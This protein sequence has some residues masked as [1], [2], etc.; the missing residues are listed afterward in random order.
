FCQ[1]QLEHVENEVVPLIIRMLAGIKVVPLGVVDWNLAF[2]RIPV[3]EIVELNRRAVVVRVVDVRVV[4][5]AAPVV[6][7]ADARGLSRA[8]GAGQNRG[9]NRQEQK[10]SQNGSADHVTN[11]P[12]YEPEIGSNAVWRA[13]GVRSPVATV[14]SP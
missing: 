1:R 2:L 4:V 11:P 10:C 12:L 7:L 6:R 13:I 5:E 3:V 8:A 9:Q 14:A